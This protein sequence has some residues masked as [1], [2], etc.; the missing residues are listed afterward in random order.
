MLMTIL[1]ELVDG[2]FDTTDAIEDRIEL[3][4]DRIFGEDPHAEKT[5]QRD[6][7]SIRSDLIDLRRAVMPL[8]EVLGA[9]S[10]QEVPWINGE[11]LVQCR[12]TYDKLCVR[13]M[14]ST[15]LASSSATRSTPIS[16]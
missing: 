9:L 16:R 2:Y 1:D 15:I 13:S 11:A 4:E 14:W 3:L 10:R 5:I 7:F 6:L 12:D 8:R